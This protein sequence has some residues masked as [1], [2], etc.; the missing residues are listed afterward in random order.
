MPSLSSCWPCGTSE[1]LQLSPQLG[2][3]FRIVYF[4]ATKHSPALLLKGVFCEHAEGL[5]C[6]AHRG[7]SAPPTGPQ[8]LGVNSSWVHRVET[9]PRRITVPFMHF[10]NHHGVAELAQRVRP[11]PRPPLLELKITQRISSTLGDRRRHD[12]APSARGLH[13][14]HEQRGE[15]EGCHDVHCQRVLVSFRGYHPLP[16][17]VAIKGASVIE[18]PMNHRKALGHLGSK[19]PHL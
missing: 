4:T 11:M 12:N 15:Q 19:S 14:G 10:G 7:A 3:L 17:V 9:K 1:S 16:R 18:E 2:P 13:V 5:R 6:S 8:H